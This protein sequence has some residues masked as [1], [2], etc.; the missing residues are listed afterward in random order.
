M[1]F[2]G[3]TRFSLYV[4]NSVAWNVSNFTEQEYIAHLFSDERM[5]VRAKIFSELSIPLMDKMKGNFEFYIKLMMRALS[6]HKV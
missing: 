2:I 3:Q 1:Y 6:L 4:P 5:N